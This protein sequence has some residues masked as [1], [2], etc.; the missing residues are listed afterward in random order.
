[1]TYKEELLW[2]LDPKRKHIND[3]E[4]IKQ[5]IAFVHSLGQKCDCVGWSTLDLSTPNATEI[6]DEIEAF[7]KNN[8]WKAR[9]WYSR[10]YPEIVSDWYEIKTRTFKNNTIGDSFTI[11]GENNCEIMRISIRAYHETDS[12]PKIWDEF[13][14]SEHFRNVCR[15]HQIGNVDFCWVE[16]KGKY[17]ATQY[18][19]LYPK[20]LIP[21]IISNRGLSLGRRDRIQA[22]GGFLP[23]I[24][25]F[26]SELSHIELP[27]CYLEKTC[28]PQELPM[29]TALPPIIIVVEKHF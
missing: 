25:S 9:G 13:Y 28:L 4:K 19:S 5:N 6:L 18:F 24:A 12:S 27:D 22:L 20:Q 11:R 17:E 29:H 2:I 21:H 23:K 3:E 10:S 16:D 8:N 26:F 15:K 7:C 1:M 14:V